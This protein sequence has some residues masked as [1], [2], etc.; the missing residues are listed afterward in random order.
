MTNTTS[1]ENT[2]RKKWASP[3]FII[4]IGQSISLLGSQ[5]VQFAWQSD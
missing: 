5:M 2:P 4:L 1:P 3:F